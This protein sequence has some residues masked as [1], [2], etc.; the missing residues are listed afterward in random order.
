M[1]ID[2]TRTLNP[3]FLNNVFKIIENNKSLREKCALN[4]EILELNQAI[5]ETKS[6]KA[7]RPKFSNSLPAH[8]KS[9]ENLN[10]FEWK[11]GKA[12]RVVVQFFTK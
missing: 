6:L 9:S 12:I 3:E 2:W 7:H 1:Y 5:F 8:I 11:I 10:I 4:C